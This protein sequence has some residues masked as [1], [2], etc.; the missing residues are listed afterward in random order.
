[1]IRPEGKGDEEGED[2]RSDHGLVESENL[3]ANDWLIMLKFERKK[4]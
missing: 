1:M 4:E 2:C 3:K